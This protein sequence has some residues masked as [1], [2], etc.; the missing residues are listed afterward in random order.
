MQL[1]KV[2]GLATSTMKHPT[3]VGWKLLLVLPLANDRATPDGEPILVIDRLGAGNGDLVI[4]TSDGKHAGE[5][6]G[7][8][9]TPARWNVIGI[10]DPEE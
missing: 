2:I 7:N 8:P 6:I 3:L 9:A 4:I 1:G 5:M 10:A